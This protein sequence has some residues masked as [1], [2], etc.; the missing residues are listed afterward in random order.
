VI[1]CV[2]PFDPSHC[3]KDLPMNSPPPSLLRTLTSLPGYCFSI[4][5]MSSCMY[6]CASDFSLQ[7]VDEPLPGCVVHKD[8]NVSVPP[9]ACGRNGPHKSM[10]SRSPGWGALVSDSGKGFLL[11]LPSVHA[12]HGGSVLCVS[13]WRV[14]GSPRT[15]WFLAMLCN[16]VYPGCPSRLW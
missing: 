14:L 8:K 12:M 10:C 11:I 16:L 3:W 1:C 7:E 13:G 4:C 9:L 2:M 6:C 5:R 15:V